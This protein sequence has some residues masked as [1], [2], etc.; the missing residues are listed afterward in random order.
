[1]WFRSTGAADA[2]PAVA[3]EWRRRAG[4]F[5]PPTVPVGWIWRNSVAGRGGA[6]FIAKPAIADPDP[7]AATPAGADQ[8]GS[9]LGFHEDF[10]SGAA[11][12]ALGEGLR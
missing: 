12:G 9:Q 7:G 10:S 11:T 6:A 1:M 2:R 5:D 3:G 8:N 4:G